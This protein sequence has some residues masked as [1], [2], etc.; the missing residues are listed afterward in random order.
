VLNFVLDPLHYDFFRNAAI[1][2]V[3]IGILCPIVGSYLVVQRMTLLGNVI[4]HAVLPGL[5]LANF[6][7][8]DLLLGAFLA[9]SLSTGLMS[10]IQTQPRIRPDAMALTLSTFFALGIALSSLLDSRLDLEALLFGD[11]LGVTARDTI[12]T[13]VITAIVILAIVLH[14]KEL[15]FYTFDPIGAKA[16][17]LPTRR[18]HLGLV[19]IVTL[20]IV[21]SM[22]TVGVLLVVSML[23]GPAVTAYLLVKELHQMMAVGVILGVLSNLIGLLLSYHLDLPSG[24]AIAILTFVLFVIAFLW[25]NW[26]DRLHVQRN[27]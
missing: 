25:T 12:E 26:R 23:V 14:Y 15:L 1:V 22:K 20:T 18:I 2:G 5:V 16:A 7:G 24:A 11:L 9:G 21:A 19:V 27:A 4:S 13:G 17:G 10:W 8:L 3:T 6:L